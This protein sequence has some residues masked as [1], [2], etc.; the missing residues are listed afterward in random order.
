MTAVEVVVSAKARPVAPPGFDERFPLLYAAAAGT[1]WRILGDREDAA[2]VAQEAVARAVARWSR[3]GED[4]VAWTV[5]VATRL[6][7]DGLRR[8]RRD[9]RR[10]AEL[11]G[12]FAEAAGERGSDA[13]L[14]LRRALRALPRRQREVVVL[15]YLADLTEADVAAVLGISQGAVK[16]A[17]SRGAAALRAHLTPEG[18]QR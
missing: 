12:G 11:S 10:F 17:A 8:R 9:A 14:D 7:L 15:R 16:S 3:V 18:E 5:T 4:P 2:D 6:A 1:A 13:A